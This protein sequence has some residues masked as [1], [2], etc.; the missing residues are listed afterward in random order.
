[1]SFSREFDHSSFHKDVSSSS[2][3]SDEDDVD[4]DECTVIN[5]RLSKKS[6]PENFDHYDRNS[7]ECDSYGGSLKRSA[8]EDFDHYDKPAK[9]KSKYVFNENITNLVSSTDVPIQENNIGRLLMVS[10]YSI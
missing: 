2:S 4:H 10:F 9:R 8:P 1:M 5:T 7:D 6:L 3:A